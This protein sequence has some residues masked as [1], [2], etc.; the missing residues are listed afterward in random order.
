MVAISCLSHF[1]LDEKN[2]LLVS[3][4]LDNNIKL[5][6][7]RQKQCITTWKGHSSPLNCIDCSPDGNWVVSGSHDRMIKVLYLKKIFYDE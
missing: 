2:N 5:W 1:P 6:D 3:G 7:I 4:S